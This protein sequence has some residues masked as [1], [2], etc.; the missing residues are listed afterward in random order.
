MSERV[1]K[2][3]KLTALGVAGFVRGD[4]YRIVFLVIRNI[5]WSVCPSR[6]PVAVSR[7]QR[8]IILIRPIAIIVG[9]IGGYGGNLVLR[10]KNLMRF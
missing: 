9:V 8:V 6:V 5:S 10:V 7:D 2:S 1:E 4:I 3:L